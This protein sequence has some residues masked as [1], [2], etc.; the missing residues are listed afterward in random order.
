[1]HAELNVLLQFLRLKNVY[2]LKKKYVAKQKSVKREKKIREYVKQTR[3]KKKKTPFVNEEVLATQVKH[4]PEKNKIL[5]PKEKNEVTVYVSRPL[6]DGNVFGKAAP[7]NY[8][9]FQL[10][11]F[12]ISKIKYTDSIIIN[13]VQTNVLCE[14]RLRR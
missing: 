5:V 4:K 12:G 11:T 10:M 2:K 7:C 3:W 9:T 6:K 14:L 8:C 13:G 1:M